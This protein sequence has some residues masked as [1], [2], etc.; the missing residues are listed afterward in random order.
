MAVGNVICNPFYF[1][2]EKQNVARVM[3]WIVKSG[4]EKKGT[5]QSEGLQSTVKHFTPH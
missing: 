1:C 2:D 5:G 4:K 3:I